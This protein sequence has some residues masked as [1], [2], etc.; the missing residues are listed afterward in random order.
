MENCRQNES[1]EWVNEAI[2]SD[3]EDNAQ[4]VLHEMVE[5]SVG[6]VVLALVAFVAENYSTL[7]RIFSSHL[8]D[9][10]IGSEAASCVS[11]HDL[12]F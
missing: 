9:E 2:E 4:G 6:S 11:S 5:R 8:V 10:Q 7:S 12:R 1:W 3:A